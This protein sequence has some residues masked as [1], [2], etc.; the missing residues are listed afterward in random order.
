MKVFCTKL[1][2][3]AAI[4]VLSVAAYVKYCPLTFF[5]PDYA[6]WLYEK[7]QIYGN[8]KYSETLVLGDSRPLSG[9]DPSLVAPNCTSLCLAGSTPIE[10][11]YL[12]KAY[13]QKHKAPKYLLLSYSQSHL[14]QAES[15][16]H[17]NVK[18][19]CLSYSDTA[20][21]VG[22]VVK[23]R[24]YNVINNSPFES[25]LTEFA[26]INDTKLGPILIAAYYYAKFYLY[27]VNWVF[28]YKDDLSNLSPSTKRTNLDIIHK[29]ETNRGHMPLDRK[30][31]GGLND[32]AKMTSFTPSKTI[33]SY[34]VRLIQ[35]CHKNNIKIYFKYMPINSD[36]NRYLKRGYLADCNKFL[37][38]LPFNPN[39]FIDKTVSFF[40]NEYFGD[41]SHLNINGAN[42]FSNQLRTELA[43]FR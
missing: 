15:F 43:S 2:F 26:A 6:M 21:I 7:E 8:N 12:L 14:M 22:E 36:S 19:K 10:G 24:D 41:V 17:R 27:R 13:L 1:T 11:Y 18:F 34:F 32:E 42:I 25:L 40:P 9:V 37:G 38:D 16:W 20:E 4:V 23:Y 39:D 28:L 30:S 3:L 31:S 35:L 5:D 29:I 33:A